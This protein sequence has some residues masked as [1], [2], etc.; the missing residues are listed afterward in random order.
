MV[1]GWGRI[2]GGCA[3]SG[4]P[5]IPAQTI[6]MSSDQFGKEMADRLKKGLDD[7]VVYRSS[8]YVRLRHLPC[9]EVLLTKA[10]LPMLELVQAAL[11][12]D[13]PGSPE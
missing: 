3:V 9:T 6:T 1:L 12:H 11:G 8:Y 13:C 10:Y 4:G 2:Q 5:E 7:F